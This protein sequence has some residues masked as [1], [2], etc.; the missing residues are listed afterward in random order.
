M[1]DR[2]RS[3]PAAEKQNRGQ[4]ADGEHRAIF[5]HEKRQP[6][7]A[8]ILGMKAGDQFAFGLGQIERST[9][10]A[11]RG[12]GEIDPEN[13]ERERIVKDVPVGEQARCC[14]RS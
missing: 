5:S 1:R 3:V 14:W 9:V 4:A 6:A 8:G 10:H 12:A 11:G 13:D 7:E 2:N